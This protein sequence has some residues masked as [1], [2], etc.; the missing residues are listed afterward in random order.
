[1]TKLTI[2][3]LYKKCS[4]LKIHKNIFIGY[5]GGVDSGTL[6]HLSYKMSKKYNFFIKVIHINHLYNKNS[7]TWSVFCKKKCNKFK[8]PIIILK[9]KKN[10]KK[11]FK[12]ICFIYI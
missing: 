7:N 6:L 5:S 9:Y 4:N 2:E 12:H 1:M 3:W 10:I 8:I 11:I